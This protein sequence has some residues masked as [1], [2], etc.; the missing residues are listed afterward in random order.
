MGGVVGRVGLIVGGRFDG[1]VNSCASGF[2]SGEDVRNSWA[3]GFSFD[4]DL[5]NSL[6]VGVGLDGGGDVKS[7]S[8]VA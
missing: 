2:S 4:V 5:M 6:A 7:L 1:G 3:A 8:G